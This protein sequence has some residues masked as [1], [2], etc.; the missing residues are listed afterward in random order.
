MGKKSYIVRSQIQYLNMCP[1]RY[2]F[3]SKMQKYI[4]SICKTDGNT[5]SLYCL[6]RSNNN[7]PID[8][9]GEK[10]IKCTSAL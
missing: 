8:L 5:V 3:F 7:N 6:Y 9:H 2:K 10:P 4:S 1:E